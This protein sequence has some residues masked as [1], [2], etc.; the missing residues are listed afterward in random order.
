MSYNLLKRWKAAGLTGDQGQ[1]FG[2]DISLCCAGSGGCVSSLGA[3][4]FKDSLAEDTS[5]PRL[6]GQVLSSPYRSFF[7][8][9]SFVCRTAPCM[10]P[11]GKHHA[12]IGCSGDLNSKREHCSLADSALEKEG[13]VSS[14]A[15]ETVQWV[16]ALAM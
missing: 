5:A 9:S 7:I 13:K 1:G 8:G 11:P 16:R 6:T 2:L 10:D 15:V 3:L 12:S 4:S 14:Q